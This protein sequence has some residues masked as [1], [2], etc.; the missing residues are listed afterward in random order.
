MIFTFS[1]IDKLMHCEADKDMKDKK[2]RRHSKES[3]GLGFV[4]KNFAT[5]MFS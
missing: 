5:S 2:H 1:N 3:G 4:R